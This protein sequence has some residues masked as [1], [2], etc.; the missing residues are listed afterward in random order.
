LKVWFS[1]KKIV[2]EF[3]L[4][5]KIFYRLCYEKEET[6]NALHI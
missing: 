3:V 4:N 2:S 5:L 1:E 6:F